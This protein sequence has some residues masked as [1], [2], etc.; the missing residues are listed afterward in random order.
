MIDSNKNVST[1]SEKSIVA[2]WNH[3]IKSCGLEREWK[4]KCMTTAQ[5]HCLQWWP[6]MSDEQYRS[7]TIDN[8]SGKFIMLEHYCHRG[9]IARH[10]ISMSKLTAWFDARK[11]KIPSWQSCW[12]WL[13]ILSRTRRTLATLKRKKTVC[14]RLVKLKT[15][16]ASNMTNKLTSEKCSIWSCRWV[17]ANDFIRAVKS[18]LLFVGLAVVRYTKI[19]L[20]RR[21]WTTSE[22]SRKRSRFQ[23]LLQFISASL[24]I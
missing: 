23:S 5:L 7:L 21:K 4:V 22:V 12:H 16:G 14:A 9:I 19:T 1:K 6:C 18:N 8:W 3:S 10:V 17:R 15:A 24:P 11:K 13:C 2:T 20:T